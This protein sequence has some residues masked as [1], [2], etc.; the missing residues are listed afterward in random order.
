MIVVVTLYF[1]RFKIRNPLKPSHPGWQQSLL[2]KE[3]A[4]KEAAEKVAKK[5]EKDRVRTSSCLHLN[6]FAGINN[7]QRAATATEGRQ[8]FWHRTARPAHDSS[9]QTVA[10]PE[11]EEAPDGNAQG[12]E[13]EHAESVEERA[14]EK[15]AV[16][17][18][19]VVKETTSEDTVRKEIEH[20]GAEGDDNEHL[21]GEMQEW[22]EWEGDWTSVLDDY[23]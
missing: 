4:D 9:H 5:A 7:L 3:K 1:R 11:N 22:G 8:H 14:A 21:D 19:T 16:R 18:E 10:R 20:V 6:A 23:L 12:E 17:E 13:I 2:A 15:D